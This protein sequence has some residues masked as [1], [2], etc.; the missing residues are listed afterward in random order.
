MPWW[1]G[2]WTQRAD[3]EQLERDYLRLTQLVL[4]WDEAW[5]IV[6]NQALLDLE[7]TGVGG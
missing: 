1:T 3:D 7:E 6:E 5:T 4:S 2:W